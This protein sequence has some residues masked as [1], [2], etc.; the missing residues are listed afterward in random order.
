[1]VAAVIVAGGIGKRMSIPLPKQFLEIKG[2][3]LIFYTIRAFQVSEVIQEICLVVPANMEDK[4]EHIKKVLKDLDNFKPK[5]LRYIIDGGSTRQES[6]W[7][8]LCALVSKPKYVA[9]HDASRPLVTPALIE[10]VARAAQRYGAAVPVI[11]VRDTIKRI[12]EGKVIATLGKEGLAIVQTPQVFLYEAILEAH[13]FAMKKGIKDAPDD[14]Y[15][16]ELAGKDI[17]LVEGEE[18]NLKLTFAS[19]LPIIETLLSK[20]C[21]EKD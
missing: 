9:I 21:H 4:E 2:K 12:N 1:M 13:H 11:P 8:G 16:L 6:V 3:P 14:A 15:L 5:K 17:F 7:N 10:K 19:D 18:W 20:A